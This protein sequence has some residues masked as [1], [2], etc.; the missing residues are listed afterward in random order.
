MDTTSFYAFLRACEQLSSDNQVAIDWSDDTAF[1]LSV[2]Q[3]ELKDAIEL[4]RRD[5]EQIT[6]PLRRQ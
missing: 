3:R 5:E 1:R 2:S 6:F 4:M